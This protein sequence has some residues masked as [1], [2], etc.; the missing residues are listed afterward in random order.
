LSTPDPTARAE[1]DE[2]LALASETGDLGPALDEGVVSERFGGAFLALADRIEAIGQL[3]R[4]LGFAAEL[5]H[6]LGRG[7][8]PA[9]FQHPDQVVHHFPSG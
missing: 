2:G 7:A 3:A 8:L 5:L 4:D 1:R 9:G 6:Q